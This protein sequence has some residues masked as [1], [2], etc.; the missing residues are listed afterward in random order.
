MFLLRIIPVNLIIL[1]RATNF[2]W[3]CNQAQDALPNFFF[4][5]FCNLIFFFFFHSFHNHKTSSVVYYSRSMSS[6]LLIA[7]YLGV[8][9]RTE[10][11]EQ[12]CSELKDTQDNVEVLIELL[13]GFNLDEHLDLYQNILQFCQTKLLDEEDFEIILK[14][15]TKIPELRK[16]LVEYMVCLMKVYIKNQVYYF[17]PELTKAIPLSTTNDL[18]ETSVTNEDLILIFKYLEALFQE[19]FVENSEIDYVLLAFLGIDDRDIANLTS[20]LLRWR[21]SSIAKDIDEQLIWKIIFTLL[22]TNQDFHKSHAFILWLRYVNTNLTDSKIFQELIHDDEYWLLLQDGL[23][24]DSHEYRKFCLSILQCSLESINTNFK[25]NYVSW[26]ITQREKYL[27]EWSR[28]MTLYEILGIDTSLNQA[29]AGKNDMTGLISPKALIPPSWGWCLL[30]TGL[31]ASLESV[32]RFTLKLLLSIPHDNLYLIKHGLPIFERAFL[33]HLMNASNLNIKVID[34][35]LDCE[36][37]YQLKYFIS[38]IVERLSAEQDVQDVTLSILKVLAGL[39][40]SYSPSRILVLHGLLDGLQ[41]RKLLKFGV[42]DIP[43]AILFEANSE[44]E[45][46]AKYH[47]TLTLRLLLHFKFDDRSLFFANLNKVIKYNGYKL[48]RD[49]KSLIEEYLDTMSL[50][51]ALADSDIQHQV[52]AICFTNKDISSFLETCEDLLLAKLLESGCRTAELK[53]FEDRLQGLI[54]S[55]ETEVIKALSNAEFNFS[56][57]SEILL[58]LWMRIKEETQSDSK[59]VLEASLYKMRLL[60]QIYEAS[61]NVPFEDSTAVV[62]FNKIMLANSHELSKT[63][64]FFYKLKD[65]IWG[66]Y[67]KLL[68]ISCE[69]TGVKDIKSILQVLNPGT[70]NLKANVSMVSVL[71]D[72]LELTEQPECVY[73]IVEFLCELWLNISAI[74]LKLHAL[75]LHVLLIKTFFHPKVVFNSESKNMMI[76]FGLSIIGGSDT[77]RRFLPTLATSL[78]KCQLYNAIE[79]EKLEWLPEVLIKAYLVHQPKMHFFILPVILAKIYDREISFD[80]NSDIY[81]EVYGE[82]EISARVKILAIFNSIKSKELSQNIHD[83]IIE[84]QEDFHLFKPLR[85]TDS[86]EE[87]IRMQLYSIVL[88]LSSNIEIDLDIFLE[89]IAIEPSPMVR[90]YIEWII[91]TKLLTNDEYVERLLNELV[92]NINNLKPSVV[93]SYMKMVFLLIKQQ[94]IPKECTLLT[95]FLNTVIP[96]STSARKMVRHFA[97]SLVISI[98]DEIER[99]K[100]PLDSHVLDIVEN[101]YINALE[102]ETFAQYRSGDDL[103]WNIVDDMTL[104]N[105]SG[106]VMLRLTDRTDLEFIKKEQFDE[107]LFAE[108]LVSLNH[109]IG[110]NPIMW[111]SQVGAP[112][113]K[114]IVTPIE[115]V[116]QSSPLQTKSGAWNTIMEVDNDSLRIAEVERSELIVV[117]S[118]VDKPP[119]LGGICRLCDVLGAGLLTLHDIEVKKHPHFKTVAV[120]ADHWMPMIEVKMENIRDY[121][122]DKKREGYTLIGL[123]QTDKSVELNNDLKFPKKSLILIGK[124]REG[125]PGDLLAE[126]D[127]CVEIKQVGIVRSMNIQTATAII[128]HAYS[129]QHC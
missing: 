112:K 48:L 82:A 22:K 30:S 99:K 120:T 80:K 6:A 68:Q 8:D 125:I 65:E 9:K 94:D 7:K 38:S 35:K 101:L 111:Y 21:M 11:I 24:S 72:Y 56:V 89:R 58:E 107:F 85:S 41:G 78:T 71:Y 17:H 28:F 129:S 91:S 43:L 74:K 104:V 27:K 31:N 108:Q 40:D 110:V 54:N 127:F 16:E 121:L 2:H 46:F 13:D 37:A 42:H 47:D 109:K 44:G 26:D 84:N 45:I 70:T 90:S 92:K 5:Q 33:P 86:Y 81:T 25:N 59:D 66:E 61:P 60:N 76:Q 73:D 18:K 36:Y 118:L 117:S 39:K 55:E 98:H 124:E 96:A 1:A 63:A 83:Y 52:L 113:K 95:R 126:L 77:R 23:I 4:F 62:E 88:S 64:R 114:V 10:L 119:N 51:D 3:S 20:K 34:G 128:V 115:P 87:W 106:G 103:L 14:F 19:N 75:S 50:E 122:L 97:L 100:L 57:T 69:R 102:S 116:V 67:Y 49:N 105:I 29:E 12:L 79:F 93:V 53:K 123:E 15:L 32:R